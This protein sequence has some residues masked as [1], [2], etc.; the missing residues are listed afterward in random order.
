MG[1]SG[2]DQVRAL[3]AGGKWDGQTAGRLGFGFAPRSEILAKRR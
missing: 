3:V 1:R 2:F